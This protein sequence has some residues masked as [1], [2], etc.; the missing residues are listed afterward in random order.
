VLVRRIYVQR[1]AEGHGFRT[2]LREP[3]VVEIQGAAETRGRREVSN[4]L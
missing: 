4:L 2:S 1:I 3:A